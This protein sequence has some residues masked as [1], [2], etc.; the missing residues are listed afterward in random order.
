MV[1][2]NPIELLRAAGFTDADASTLAEG[3]E[4]PYY[5]EAFDRAGNMSRLP[6]DSEFILRVR[7]DDS[8]EAVIHPAQLVVN[9]GDT[10]TL[11]GGLSTDNSGRVV[12]YAWDVD[13][14][15]GVRFEPPDRTG[16]FITFT[17]ERP[18][19]VTL[20]V[21]DAAGNHA[22]AAAHID[23]MDRVP[24]APPAFD[25]LV[26]AIRSDRHVTVIGTA[27]PGATVEITIQ[28]SPIPPTTALANVAARFSQTVRDL[29][30]GSYRVG[31][32]AKDPAG[33]TSAQSATVPLIIDTT[34]PDIDIVFQSE[35]IPG[36]P[37]RLQADNTIAN[38]RPQI[39]VRVSDAAGLAFVDVRLFEGT[40]EVSLVGGKRRS[41][42]GR[43]QVTEIVEPVR[44]LI[45][46]VRY[47][48]QVVAFDLAQLRSDRTLEFHINL[49][50]DDTTAPQVA[51]ISPPA[52]GSLTGLTRPELRANF[53][54]NERGLDTTTIEMRLT[55]QEGQIN[56]ELLTLISS[57]IHSVDVTTHAST[58]LVPGEYVLTAELRDRNSNIGAGRRTFSV[59]G[60]PPVSSS[61]QTPPLKIGEDGIAFVGVSPFLIEGTLDEED[62]PGGTIVEFFVNGDLVTTATVDGATGTF[63]SSVPLVEGLN[64]V[65]LVTVNAIGVR[66]QPSAPRR[67]VLDTQAPE[68]DML[69]PSD[70]ASLNNV[71][72]IRAIMKDSIVVSPTVSGVDP[73]SIQAILDEMPLPPDDP[74]TPEIDGYQYDPLFRQFIYHIAEPFEG[75]ART[76]TI[77][78]Q[79]ADK[80]GNLAKAES[81]FRVDQS[82]RDRTGPV[83]SGFDPPDETVLNAAV[84]Q[85]EDFAL[86]ASVYDIESGLEEVQIRLDGEV[87]SQRTTTDGSS[88]VQESRITHHASRITDFDIGMIA[89]TPEVP[90]ADGDHLMTIY[91]RDQA[92]NERIV[93]S[94]FT[95][96]TSTSK[97]LLEPLPA[98]LNT[99]RILINGAS[100]PGAKITLL[101][102]DQPAGTVTTN[103][104]G[105]FSANIQLI[106][107]RNEIFA[108]ATDAT[109][110]TS[111]ADT[112]IVT[113]DVRSPVIG[114]PAPEPDSRLQDARAVMSVD[115]SD[116]PSGSGIDLGG[117]TFVLDG[118]IQIS[119]E[120]LDFNDGRLTY[121]PTTD[122]TEG[123]HV[124]RVSAVDMVGNRETFNSGEFFVDF[125][126][127]PITQIVPAD[128]E[129]VSNPEV[130]ITAIVEGDDIQTVEVKLH[131]V[132][133][134]DIPLPDIDFDSASGRLRFRPDNPLPNGDHTLVI[135]VEDLAGNV[136]EASVNFKVDTEITDETAPFVVPR[137]PAPG[138]AVSTTSF[139][140]IKFEVVDADSGV[141]FDT[142]TIEINGVVYNPDEL[143][144]GGGGVLNRETGEVTI[145]ARFNQQQ[146]G[147]GP[148][149]GFAFDPLELGVLEDP[150]ELG[151]LEDPLELGSL[152]DPLEL[153]SLE[154]PL[155]LGSLEDPLELGSLEDP[156]ELGSLED[157][158]ELGSLE[159]PTG[160][161]NGLN[162]IS[163]I[164]SDN[165]GNLSSFSYNFDVSLSPPG[166]PL[167]G[168]GTPS[169]FL[170]N[171]ILTIP[172]IIGAGS[173]FTIQFNSERN[174]TAQLDISGLDSTQEDPLDLELEEISPTPFGVPAGARRYTG[175]VEISPDTEIDTGGKR[176]RL[177]V[178]NADG[179][180]DTRDIQVDFTN[181]TIITPSVIEVGS[182][183]TLEFTSEPGI[184]AQLDIS[185]LDSTQ[186]S[187]TNLEL[188]EVPP[189]SFEVL[190]GAKW[191]K[192]VVSVSSNAEIG[193]GQKV[194]R[195]IIR[196][197]NG[198]TVEIRN[199]RVDFTNPFGLSAFRSTN[200]TPATI[201]NQVALNPDS[202]GV[203]ATTSGTEINV[204]LD[205]K[206]FTNAPEIPLTGRIPDFTGTSAL[207]E[208]FVNGNSMGVVPVEPNG[209]FRFSRI[210]L[211]L[212]SNR[213]TSF[214]QSGAQLQSP[215]S[216]PQTVIF[217]QTSP[218][219]E[220]VN[221]P[222][223]TSNTSL[224]VK[225]RYS[226]NIAAKPEFVTLIIN[227]EAQAVDTAQNEATTSVTLND[228]ENTLVLSAIDAAG[229]LSAPVETT[230]ILDVTPPETAPSNLHASISF[231]GTEIALNWEADPNAE[232]Y[233]LY[234]SELP[235]TQIDGRTPIA[236][237]L[238]T[239]QFTDVNVNVG[240]TYYY[241]LTS[242]SPAGVEGV[243]LSESVNVTILFAPRGG[244]AAISDGT[245]LTTPAQA[246]SEDPTLYTAVSIETPSSASL[247]LLEG[248]I[249]GT[250]RRFAAI[251]QSGSA[252]TDAFVQPVKIALPYMTDTEFRQAL[253]VFHLDSG[254]WTQLEG[255]TI[256]I[257]RGVITVSGF[258]FG[259]YQLAAPVRRPWDVNRDGVVDI[260]DL[261]L[262]GSHFGQT[263]PGIP[264]D[265]NR[266]EVVNIIDL[267][268]VG[269]HFGEVF[270][271]TAAAPPPANRGAQAVVSMT[272]GQSTQTRQGVQERLVTVEVNADSTLPLGGFMFDVGYDPY[273]LAL[274]D[275]Q[276]GTLL[277]RDGMRSFWLKPKSSRGGSPRSLPSRCQG[278]QKGPP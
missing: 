224:R 45:D 28:G 240:V 103:L 237:K 73:E 8:P 168:F 72:G 231:S 7:D 157:P 176:I 108:I 112:L 106:E 277:K 245:R 155:E 255:E 183:F 49:A 201:A 146:F 214:V 79:V 161:A 241:A 14:G 38:V 29:P 270:V 71:N 35:V 220:F 196:N 179:E 137:F 34:P 187:L 93:N 117:L 221:L 136:G 127:P 64:E 175:I 115:I 114:N 48:I 271:P 9:Q 197:A 268:L 12:A 267:V 213:V 257:D 36:S 67:I 264:G 54:D 211:T 25:R 39:P 171:N 173:L 207:V 239:T 60:E 30:D 59:L 13:A 51:F 92:G 250:A 4:F 188:E 217:D 189:L 56:L 91:A 234:R 15:D 57:D 148:A 88:G 98:L 227:G 50:Q 259:V 209:T 228:G 206:I 192:A 99:R 273:L 10:A 47:T 159:R 163:I 180:V 202:I 152:E 1:P 244:T 31:G 55:G 140:A 199:I 174:I 252:F 222:T 243:R 177:I 24:P 6:V 95:V 100:E 153:G 151:A 76:H 191:Y 186:E 58:D 27:E 254:E 144:G 75:N 94:T 133:D 141:N 262:V 85:H 26:P 170:I 21:T 32:V 81:D 96:D 139:L 104:D 149:G 164:T 205:G 53:S 83:I 230:V 22:I 156:L 126:P 131:A 272:A 266:D 41:A 193:S 181:D 52:D 198:A 66:S 40:T 158:L 242:I 19:D 80:L 276:E 61:T 87:V 190:L 147:G 275:L 263:G 16:R 116:G 195:L 236:S 218:T 70:D 142:M 78:I 128:G 169:I 23:V 172:R 249:D 229:N 101:V 278:T 166:A 33:N 145:F 269:S 185:A 200:G 130:E 5:V 90:L 74:N 82:R 46:G 138:Q 258:R 160:L 261:V 18:T 184:T 162:T 105:R 167:L 204:G 3:V 89:F 97:P 203:E 107:G 122:L 110:N 63:I 265:I 215:V 150:L 238:K 69:E 210:L 102:N 121:T 119:T 124:F 225:T 251:S 194:I 77:Y 219:V 154:D 118:V 43:P 109:G 232:T 223:D 253:R 135:T 86:R 11:D 256:D 248:A 233:H 182:E 65:V 37:N 113:V 44:N 212:G 120:A 165:L 143:F 274:V 68:I 111:T 208:V 246:I 247:P 260:F 216:A 123:T 17:V 226:D 129:I 62:I 84:L 2:D 235:I 20:K 178:T 134:V 132:G 125:T 42:D